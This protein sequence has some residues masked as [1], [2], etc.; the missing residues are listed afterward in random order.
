T[1]GVQTW[2]VRRALAGQPGVKVDVAQVSA[3]LSSAVLR[4]LRVEQAGTVIVAR[5]GSAGFSATDYLFCKRIN[6][7]RVALRGVEVD[8]RKAASAPAPGGVPKAALAPFAGILNAIRLP[9][10][11]RVGRLE[12][13]A[14]VLLADSRTAQLTIDGGGI[15]PGESGTIKWKA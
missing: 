2:A 5:E 6:V 7:D 15:A 12:V 9:G 4:D 8:A 3:G 13:E 10:E 1:S 11:V 14:K